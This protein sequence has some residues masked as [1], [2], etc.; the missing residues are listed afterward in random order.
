MKALFIGGTG[1]ISTPVSEIAVQRGIDL[2]HLNRGN[3]EPIPGVKSLVA[4]ITKPKELEAALKGHTW[5]V[6]VNWIAFNTTDVERDIELFK[7]KT[8]QYVFISSASCYQKPP[9]S[10][11]I[12]E[13]TPLKNPYWDYSREKIASEEV[14]IKAFREEDFPMT[15]VR[16]S[17]T[18]YS[19]FPITLGGWT[20]YTAV[21][22]MKKGLPVV[23]QGDGTSLWTVTHAR[24]FAKAFLGLMN[25]PLAIGESYHITSDEALTWNQIYTFLADAAGVEA[26][27]VHIPSQKIIEYADRN[28]FPSEEGNLWG[29]KSHCALFD[30]SKIKKLVPDY[31]ATIPFSEGIKETLAWFESK[32]ERMIINETT[33]RFLSELVKNY[34]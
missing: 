9:V 29:D 8:K 3:R 27:I 26:N 34:G 12:T 24:D 28:G 23:V 7:G 5:D 32:P 31:V 13:S 10:P 25:H 18:Y 4:D 6:V 17:H 20:E 1:N 14:L 21:H 15:I 2:Y 22:R 33:N 30:N 16:P 19:V 11:I